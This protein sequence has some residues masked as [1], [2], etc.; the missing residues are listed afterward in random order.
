MNFVLCA[1]ALNGDERTLTLID[2]IVDR[3]EEEVHQIEVPDADL[4]QNSHWYVQAR[5]MRKRLLT[6]SA[7]K[8]P[9][10]TDAQKGIHT[11]NVLIGSP[12]DAVVAAKLALSPL[13]ILVEDREADGV[14]LEI[15]IE[16]LASMELSRLFSRGAKA[17]PRAWDIQTAGGIGSI[18]QRIERILI[19]AAENSVPVRLVVIC[20]SD[21]RWPGDSSH[22]SV[23]ALRNV[24]S[25]CAAAGIPL[26]VL[27]KRA[28]ENYVPDEVFAGAANGPEGTAT[29][30]KVNALF[31]RTRAQRDH[32]PLKDGM[33]ERE[34]EEVISRAFYSES[35]R[36][37]LAVLESRIFPKRPRMM[38]QLRETLNEHFAA[39]G[40]AARDG[41]GELTLLIETIA[42]EL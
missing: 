37:D 14:L 21:A 16:N 23:L 29:A 19:E 4:L 20:D 32:F 6:T 28:A 38:L 27:K 31:R 15:A 1:P 41:N 13:I 39:A 12:C 30:T 22:G 18:P 7:A 40:L 11:K 10:R 25:A 42:A 36:P 35:E 8:P 26:H 17:V 5:A 3:V 2:R 33:C 34:R 24:V 9:R